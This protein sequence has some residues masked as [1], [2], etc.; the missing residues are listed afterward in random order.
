MV[1]VDIIERL[2]GQI[3]F[4]SLSSF[5]F[6][7][8]RSD[9]WSS[10]YRGPGTHFA[11][12]DIIEARRNAVQETIFLLVE[13]EKFSIGFGSVLFSK[14]DKNKTKWQLCAIPLG[15]YVK[16]S[17]EMYPNNKDLKK[18][19]DKKLFMN[20]KALQKASIVFA[21]P[22][23]NF[24]L[25]FLL[26]ITIFF[27]FGKNQIDPI[28]GEVDKNSPAENIGILVKDKILSLNNT[29]VDSYDQVYSFLENTNMNKISLE[30]LRDNKIIYNF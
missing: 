30:I 9:F 17:G 13:V 14:I 28:V 4:F 16:F 29:K 10:P 15:G 6:R 11:A 20:K 8:P 22:L 1:R 25:S 12:R 7:C 18:N 23:A 21:G 19:K 3:S 26:F 2:S 24:I 27:F 5:Q